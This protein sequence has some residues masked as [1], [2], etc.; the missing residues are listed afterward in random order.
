MVHIE[1]GDTIFDSMSSYLQGDQLT[2]LSRQVGAD[3]GATSNALSMALPLLISA[4]SRNAATPNGA[5]SLEQALDRDHDGSLL[6]NF[7]AMFGGQGAS[8]V[9][10]RALNG[11]GI[12]EHILGT[13]RAPVEQGIGKASGLNMQQVSKL[14]TLAAPL[15]MAYLARR[16]KAQSAGAIGPVLDR[17][18]EELER[19]APGAGGLFS[20][21]FG[22]G[23]VDAS[24][25]GIFGG[26][27]GKKKP[28]ADFSDVES[29][30]S[31][32]AS[33]RP[34]GGAAGRSYT[35][36]AGDSLSKIAQREYGSAGK[37]PAIFEANRDK[38]KDPNLIHPGQVL[39]LPD[40]K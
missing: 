31:S 26:L 18:R 19:R 10:P 1:T 22:G 37:W 2:Q 21:I 36:V 29:G 4:L 25:M 23:G 14:L 17:E 24:Q 40:I 20:N 32:T 16:K 6:D 35:V 12:L 39:T 9:S 33:P 7:S 3:E 13:K 28:T 38:I 15:V 34:A 27:F 30:G 11:A 5:S 8:N